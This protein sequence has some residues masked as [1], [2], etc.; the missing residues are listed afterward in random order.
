MTSRSNSFDLSHWGEAILKQS[1]PNEVD[2]AYYK[3]TLVKSIHES[4]DVGIYPVP[5]G[6]A[7]RVSAHIKTSLTSMAVWYERQA[8]S[9]EVH[10]I[11][12]DCGRLRQRD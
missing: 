9:Y 7:C 4:R 11:P 6:A 3:A 12:P 2:M 1:S 8:G 5:L 10:S